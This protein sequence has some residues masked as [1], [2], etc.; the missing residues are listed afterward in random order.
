MRDHLPLY[1]I[2]PVAYAVILVL[3]M[4]GAWLRKRYNTKPTQVAIT[5]DNHERIY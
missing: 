1:L 5:R 3:V 2:L 4:G